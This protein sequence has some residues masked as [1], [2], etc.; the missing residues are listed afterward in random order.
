MELPQD[1]EY[2]KALD[3]IL[4]IEP[5]DDAGA[6]TADRYE[7]QAAMATADGLSLYLESIDDHGNLDDSKNPRILCEYHEDWVAIRDRDAQLN[8][9]KHKDPAFGAYTTIKQLV[10]DGGLAHLFIAWMALHQM[11]LCRLVTSAGLASGP[12]RDLERATID[13]R[14]LGS[15]GDSIQIAIYE[16]TIIGLFRELD[17]YADSLPENWRNGSGED[18]RDPSAEHRLLVANFLSMLTIDHSLIQRRYLSYAAPG[19]YVTPILG[20]LGVP[21]NRAEAVWNA[22]LG[23]FRQRMRAAGPRPHGELPR[24]LAFPRT[25]SGLFDITQIEQGL[26]TR[27]VTIKDIDT[28]VRTAIRH[29]DGYKTLPAIRRLS[30][31]AIK[32]ESGKCGDNSIERAE[33]LKLEYQRYWSRRTGEDPTARV[34]KERMTRRLLKVA[35]DATVNVAMPETQAGHELWIEIQRLL[36]N[37]PAHD[38]PPGMDSD[39][40]LG[41]VCE[42]TSKCKVWFSDRFDIDAVIDERRA[43]RE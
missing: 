22:V 21:S 30:K 1:G 25:T 27:I 40:L 42:L 7:W 17:R 12:A 10:D 35:D 33:H 8:S 41:G 36:D 31:L 19:M 37:I 26:T 13:L 39:L 3:Y 34:E 18:S 11:P 38:T 14:N 24:V 9:A 4:T 15:D 6:P 32:M 20:K 2:K 16:P 5:P 29:P 23:L 28:A 43:G